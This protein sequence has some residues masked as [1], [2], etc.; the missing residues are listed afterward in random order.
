MHVTWR[1]NIIVE[2]FFR[3]PT[4]ILVSC[5]A[6]YQKCRNAIMIVFTLSKAFL[7]GQ[8]VGK[9]IY[10]LHKPFSKTKKVLACT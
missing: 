5:R 1:E 9:I 4:N 6:K 2:V 10:P 7:G 3:K 8:F